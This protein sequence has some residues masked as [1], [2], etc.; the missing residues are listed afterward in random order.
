MIL[1]HVTSVKNVP[2]IMKH[3]LRPSRRK[4]FS[5]KVDIA[6]PFRKGYLYFVSSPEEVGDL[7]TALASYQYRP[8]RLALLRIDVSDSY[9]Y[10]LESDVDP[11][12]AGIF[13]DFLVSKHSIPVGSIQ[14]LGTVTTGYT[15]TPG[16]WEL[17]K[18]TIPKVSDLPP[19][20]GS[21]VLLGA[22]KAMGDQAPEGWKFGEVS[23]TDIEELGRIKTEFGTWESGFKD[24]TVLQD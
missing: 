21:K 5:R 2:M 1:Y 4:G 11:N 23:S 18:T 16:K 8:T 7:L 13:A 9:P 22:E 14:N 10:F 24:P 6:K 12:A 20:V 19:E 15:Q 3:G 17:V